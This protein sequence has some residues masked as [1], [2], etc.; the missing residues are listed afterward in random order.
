MKIFLA[1][2]ALGRFWKEG[3]QAFK[4]FSDFCPF[5]K[6]DAIAKACSFNGSLNQIEIFELPKVLADGGLC[7]A[8]FRNQVGIDAGLGMNQVLQDGNA[9]WVPE[10]FGQ[11]GQFILLVGKKICFGNSHK[12]S[13]YYDERSLVSQIF[14]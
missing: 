3:E 13:Q 6:I 11:E 14:F 9:G 10:H 4:F 1:T 8:Q 5:F 2:I 12:T 7:K